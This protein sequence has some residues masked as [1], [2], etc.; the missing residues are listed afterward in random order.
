MVEDKIRRLKL[1]A[2]LRKIGTSVLCSLLLLSG[3]ESS[4]RTF[5]DNGNALFLQAVNHKHVSATTG[6]L[7]IYLF[8]YAII[9][10]CIYFVF[11]GLL[12]QH[13]EIPR[14]GVESEL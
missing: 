6:K 8:I 12:L 4:N 5:C 3:P 7:N 2:W 11:V 13:M 14:L 10:L 9:Y 1:G